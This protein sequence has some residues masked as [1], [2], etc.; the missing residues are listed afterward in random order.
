MSRKSTTAC[1]RTQAED[2]LQ[3]PTALT[4]V[5][6]ILRSVIHDGLVWLVILVL[7]GTAFMYANHYQNDVLLAMMYS[8]LAILALVSGCRNWQ[9]DLIEYQHHVALQRHREQG[10]SGNNMPGY[11]SSQRYR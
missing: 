10:N 7:A 6:H 8:G 11:F 1:K 2:T 4:L 3:R 5:M 9:N